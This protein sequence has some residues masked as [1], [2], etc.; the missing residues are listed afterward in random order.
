MGEWEI[1][2][3]PLALSPSRPFL[4][5]VS[6]LPVDPLS[7]PGYPLSWNVIIALTEGGSR[8]TILATA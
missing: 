7:L 4:L 8:G 6:R 3:R 2:V 1:R 5:P